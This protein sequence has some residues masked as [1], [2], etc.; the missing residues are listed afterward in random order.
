LISPEAS[1][2]FSFSGMAWFLAIFSSAAAFFAY[3]FLLKK[4]SKSQPGL[5][6]F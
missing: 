2:L 6:A 4:K 5:R 1:E 3:F